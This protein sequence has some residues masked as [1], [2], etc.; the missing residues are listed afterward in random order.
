MGGESS[1]EVR[2]FVEIVEQGGA[3]LRLLQVVV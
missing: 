2:Y 3:M 1:H